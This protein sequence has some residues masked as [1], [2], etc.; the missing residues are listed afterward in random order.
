MTLHNIFDHL[1][2]RLSL[3]ASHAAACAARRPLVAAT[4][5][6]A[7]GVAAGAGA[8]S[9]T[10]SVQ[11]ALLQQR[12]A[13]QSAALEATRS[14]AQH[15]VNALAARMAELQAQANRLNALGERL[16]QAGKLDDGEFDFDA[17]AGVGGVA[18]ASDMPVPEL[19]SGME[20][21]DAQFTASG[22]QLSVLESL[23]FN[24]KLD[25]DATPS[26]TPVSHGYITS[27]FGRR[28]D[29]FGGGGEYHRGIDFH[30]RMGDPV[31]SVADGVV[32]Y[33]GVRSGYGNVVEVD[34]GNGYVTRYAHNSRLLVRV[35][36]LVHSGQ[37]LAR[38]GSSGRST[39]AHVHFEVWDHGKVVDPRRF[40][41]ARATKGRG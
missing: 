15:E 2:Q 31:L 28:A 34:H 33:A 7:A 26:R 36:D 13:Q 5:L 22:A 19:R 8:R 21:L 40:L 4:L 12:A 17:P 32:S 6:L 41:G 25:A 10:D 3:G 16:A 14:Q 35:G 23:L 24:R 37:Q 9:G 39:G 18:R 1:R 29:P 11:L 38:A 27:G 30:A 20:R